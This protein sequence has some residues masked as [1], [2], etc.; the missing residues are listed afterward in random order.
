MKKTVITLLLMTAG[1]SAASA[2]EGAA[3]FGNP[4]MNTY[5]CTATDN[6]F[7]I[8]GKPGKIVFRTSG[9]GI[10]FL[11]W[12][13]AFG[14]CEMDTARTF[15]LKQ[16]SQKKIPEAYRAW[17]NGPTY[18]VYYDWY[19]TTQYYFTLES[20]VSEHKPGDK[21]KLEINGDDDDG[22]FIYNRQFSCKVAN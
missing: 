13:S 3:G 21:V 1:L 17:L 7:L 4:A 9:N 18:G 22:C 20:A 12:K 10:Q 8:D 11:E 15:P 19:Y 6:G 16:T 5:T 14:G 2:G